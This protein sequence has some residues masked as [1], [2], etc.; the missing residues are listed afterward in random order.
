MNFGYS[1][2]VRLGILLIV[3][4]SLHSSYRLAVQWV[5]SD[6]SFVGNDDVSLNEKRFDKIKEN[7][8]SHGVVGYWPNGSPAT[9]EQLMFGNAG[10]LQH[11]FLTQ[12]ALAPVIV[13]PTLG[14][15]VIVCN[16]RP[17]PGIYYPGPPGI[18]ESADRKI[19]DFGN[20]V[21]L[22]TRELR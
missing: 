14:Q 8:P 12:Y 15:S 6:L 2:R 1:V 20:G 7:L 18:K 10:D 21:Q 5:K 4:L 19:I 16:Y 9:L 3:A 13:S 22:L 17:M 11:W